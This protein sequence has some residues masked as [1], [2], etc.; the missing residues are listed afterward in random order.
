MYT[1]LFV[2]VSLFRSLSHRVGG[3]SSYVEPVLAS[4]GP[5]GAPC[6]GESSSCVDQYWVAQNG[7]GRIHVGQLPWGRWSQGANFGG[8]GPEGP[9]NDAQMLRRAKSHSQ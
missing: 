8:T 2:S 9:P 6:V 5:Q 7:G 3:F 4:T 1:C